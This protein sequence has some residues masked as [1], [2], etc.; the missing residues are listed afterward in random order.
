VQQGNHVADGSGK[1][2]DI[3][4]VRKNIKNS[5]CKYPTAS[6]PGLGP[7]H[8]PVPWVPGAVS[9]GLKRPRPGV[10]YSPPSGAEVKNAWRYNSTAPTRLHGVVLS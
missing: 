9:L 5:R 2:H 1:L 10:D 7:T 3:S 6:R 8:P 4:L